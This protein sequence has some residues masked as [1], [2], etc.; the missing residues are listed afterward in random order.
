MFNL[1]MRN[2]PIPHPTSHMQQGWS[3]PLM[4]LTFVKAATTFAVT[5]HKQEHIVV[6]AFI[7]RHWKAAQVSLVLTHMCAAY[8]CIFSI[9]VL[10]DIDIQCLKLSFY[11]VHTLGA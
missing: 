4:L 5:R 6:T 2:V 9:C 1:Q 7:W 8:M 11:T 3:I 10:Y